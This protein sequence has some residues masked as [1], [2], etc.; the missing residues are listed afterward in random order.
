MAHAMLC[1]RRWPPDGS[2]LPVRALLHYSR[3]NV[4]HVLIIQKC[5][6]PSGWRVIRIQSDRKFDLALG[7]PW[8][9]PMIT[10]SY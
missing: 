4:G 3:D 5:L 9:S 8:P 6:G 2:F 10:N 7:E 1:L